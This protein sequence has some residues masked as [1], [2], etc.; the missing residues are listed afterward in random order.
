VAERENFRYHK[1]LINKEK[2]IALKEGTLKG[3]R[4]KKLFNSFRGTDLTEKK[5]LVGHPGS[6]KG[7]DRDRRESTT[8]A[9]VWTK[10]SLSQNSHSK[11]RGMG[12]LYGAG[13][14]YVKKTAVACREKR[15][16]QHEKD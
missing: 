11:R 6:E 13:K 9:L 15:K 8:L 14:R 3:S 7:S 16:R 12:P 10:K 2:G 1:A 5:N 4:A